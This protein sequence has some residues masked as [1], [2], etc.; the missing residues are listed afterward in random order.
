MAVDKRHGAGPI[1][2]SSPLDP[3][4]RGREKEITG[5]SIGVLKSQS[6]PPAKHL[7]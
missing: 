3:Q 1:A 7:P 6:P 5:N 4:A 2:K